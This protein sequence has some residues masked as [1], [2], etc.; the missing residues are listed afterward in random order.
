M[1]RNPEQV[2]ILGEEYAIQ[3][4]GALQEGF[5]RSFASSVFLASEHV[6]PAAAQCLGNRSRNVH[7]HVESQRHL[8][9]V[10]S[11]PQQFLA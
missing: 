11:P 7:V 9:R 2:V 10:L 3:L 5:S 1:P 6:D 4:N 8:S